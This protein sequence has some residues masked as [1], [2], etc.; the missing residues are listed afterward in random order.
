MMRGKIKLAPT[1]CICGWSGSIGVTAPCP[2][3]GSRDRITPERGR[4]LAALGRGEQPRIP[5][6]MRQ[7]FARLHL[8]ELA[9]P[10]PPAAGDKREPRI[11]RLTAAG[12]RA[13]GLPT[14]TMAEV[15]TTTTEGA[16]AP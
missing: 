6:V 11:F 16:T 4:I 3:C 9:R 8:I 10:R 13:V 1:R 2:S 12:A 15:P 14:T 7:W 5:G